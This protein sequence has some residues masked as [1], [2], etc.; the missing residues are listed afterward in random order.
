MTDALANNEEKVEDWQLVE[1]VLF[2]SNHA[3]TVHQ[4]KK[5]TGLQE[6]GKVLAENSRG[7][8][9]MISAG[10]GDFLILLPDTA[11]QGA[12][13]IAQR[14]RKTLVTHMFPELENDCVRIIF[15]L[16]STSGKDINSP[17]DLLAAAS[18]AL[19]KAQELKDSALTV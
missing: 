7:G 13:Q 1:A 12:R 4:I 17:A 8:D 6:A 11:A 19:E 14:I 15:G 5:I 16:A 3:L 10:E 2:S 18:D 9:I